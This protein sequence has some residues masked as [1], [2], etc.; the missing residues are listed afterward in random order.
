MSVSQAVQNVL[1]TGDAPL[2]A[3]SVRTMEQW[4]L[5]S[6]ARQNFALLLLAVFAAI[7]LLLATL[8]IYGVISYG[9]T[10]RRR[11]IGIRMALGADGA[12]VMRLVVGQGLVLTLMG[13][14]SGLAG[15]L[16]L[17]RFLVGLLYSV[18]PTDPL[19]FIAVSL[20]LTGVAVLACYVPARR[21][22]KVDPMATLRYE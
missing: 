22:A 6:T 20:M 12:N 17:T 15:A 9:V 19:T 14:A 5:N 13:V 16:A 3:M 10:Q 2:P 11:E 4:S 7:A 1:L 21:A 8:G 18:R